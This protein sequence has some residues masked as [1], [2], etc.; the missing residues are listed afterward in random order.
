MFDVESSGGGDQLDDGPNGV[1][2]AMTGG[3]E[4]AVRAILGI[5]TMMEA[6]VGQRCAQA[7]MEEQE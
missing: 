2:G 6:A 4:T 3:F 1:V 7:L 5:W